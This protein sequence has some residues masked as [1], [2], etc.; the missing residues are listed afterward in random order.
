MAQATNPQ[1]ALE[2]GELRRPSQ[3]PR[4]YGLFEPQGRSEKGS[5]D[6]NLEKR[7]RLRDHGEDRGSGFT[8]FAKDRSIGC[9]VESDW[10]GVQGGKWAH[11]KRCRAG[12]EQR[13]ANVSLTSTLSQ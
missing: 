5:F 4:K 11:H 12:E 1:G 6:G 8:N 3:I 2:E 7:M 10:I 13:G 9:N